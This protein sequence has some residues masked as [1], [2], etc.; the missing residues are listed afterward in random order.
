VLT[1][2]EYNIEATEISHMVQFPLTLH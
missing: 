2:T 1:V